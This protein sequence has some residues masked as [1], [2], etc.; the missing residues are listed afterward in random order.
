MGWAIFA[1]CLNLI[2]SDG[3][4]ANA[5]VVAGSIL[6]ALGLIWFGSAWLARLL[7]KALKRSDFP[8]AFI[9]VTCIFVFIAAALAEWFGTHP[10][11][12]AFLVGVVF[13]QF[14]RDE[15]DRQAGKAIRTIAVYLFAPLYFVAVGLKVNLAEHF[16]L[17]LV[18]L[19]TMVAV[20]SKVLGAGLG[21]RLGGFDSRTSLAIGFGLN[22]R[23]A[24][25]IIL[26]TVAL[27]NSLV[28][29]RIFVALVFMSLVT[30]MVS[31]VVL[32]RVMQA[33]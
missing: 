23:G 5:P 26:A 2:R 15:A 32:K 29:E 17:W 18:L 4:D 25:G 9:I 28:D 14:P 11:F 10:V 30:S 3:L 1:I 13:A 19:V 31:G 16:D 24:I 20:V 12:G 33:H 27:D 8:G 21:A 22:A 6:A 7:L